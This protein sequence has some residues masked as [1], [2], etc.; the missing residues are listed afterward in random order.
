MYLLLSLPVVQQFSSFSI[1]SNPWISSLKAEN[2][3]MLGDACFKYVIRFSG[4]TI[5]GMLRIN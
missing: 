5:L 3:L 1:I 4:I 2:M